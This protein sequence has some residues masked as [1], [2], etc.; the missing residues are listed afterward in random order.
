ME[1]IKERLAEA[2]QALSTFERVVGLAKPT[3]VERDAAIQRFEYTFEMTWKTAQAYLA[4]QGLLE[5]S[6]PKNVIRSS[7][8]MEMFDEETAG[9]IIG[10]ANDRNL[11]VHTYKEEFAIQLYSRLASHAALLRQW[12]TEIKKRVE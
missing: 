10:M 5:I 9:K 3:D 4:D 6:S 12:L 1:R 2:F 8:K 11:T 7:F